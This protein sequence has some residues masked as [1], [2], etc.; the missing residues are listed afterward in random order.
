MGVNLVT[1]RVKE[2]LRPTVASQVEES[3]LAHLEDVWKKEIE[4]F[5]QAKQRG[6]PP[7]PLPLLEII[8]NYEADR[9]KKD[10]DGEQMAAVD[11]GEE[12]TAP[13]TLKERLRGPLREGL[14]GV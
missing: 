5:E 11:V 12:P 3:A 8:E 9:S 7:A 6:T 14:L 4:I 13:L 1:N 2:R 10:E